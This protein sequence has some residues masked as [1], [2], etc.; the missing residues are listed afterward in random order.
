MLIACGIPRNRDRCRL[1]N[2][3]LRDNMGRPHDAALFEDNFS[4]PDM[5]SQQDNRRSHNYL[6]HNLSSKRVDTKETAHCGLQ[7][8]YFAE[9]LDR[10]EWLGNQGKRS[11]EQ[12]IIIHLVRFN[13][14]SC[15][16]CQGK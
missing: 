16:I 13:S 7:R 11:I 14:L 3:Y 1:Y 6:T 15:G 4:G 2:Y 8:N 12:W 5:E 10:V 9:L